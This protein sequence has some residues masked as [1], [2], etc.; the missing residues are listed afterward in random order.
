MLRHYD[1]IKQW[2]MVYVLNDEPMRNGLNRVRSVYAQPR[3]S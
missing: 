3:T 2:V 1:E